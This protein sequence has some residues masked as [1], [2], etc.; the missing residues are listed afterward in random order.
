MHI[1]QLIFGNELR[2]TATTF[3]TCFIDQQSPNAV[4]FVLDMALRAEDDAIAWVQMTSCPH[5]LSSKFVKT[6]SENDQWQ[7]KELFMKKDNH[8]LKL[9][10]KTG[11][12]NVIKRALHA[13]SDLTLTADLHFCNLWAP[14][15]VVIEK[16]S[17]T[18][19]VTKMLILNGV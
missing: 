2:R 8:H 12:P 16:Q 17:K 3:H 14:T 4:C 9:F 11:W 18:K 1:N 10:P 6:K 5:L 7:W 13:A 19:I 15:R